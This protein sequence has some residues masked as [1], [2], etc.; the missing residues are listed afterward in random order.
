M[1]RRPM[2]RQVLGRPTMDVFQP[3]LRQAWPPEW[4]EAA[5]CVQDVDVQCVLQFTLVHAAGCA[6]HRHTSRVIHRSELYHVCGLPPTMR[7][8]RS[9]AD[10]RN[11]PYKVRTKRRM[12][13]RRNA[14]RS[15]GRRADSSNLAAPR[16]LVRD[17]SPRP[18][19]VGRSDGTGTPQSAA[20]ARNR[21]SV[22]GI[23]EAPG[24]TTSVDG[25]RPSG[26]AP[27]RLSLRFDRPPVCLRGFSAPRSFAVVFASYNVSSCA[28]PTGLRWV[29]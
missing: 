24:R 29:R 2:R 22:C 13:T 28:L 9:R 6:L 21:Y 17:R 23:L 14:G 19:R 4:P 7:P 15:A 11:E 20:H 1:P 26:R 25:R 16:T 5:M 3:T 27:L 18:T 10:D 12:H 8:P